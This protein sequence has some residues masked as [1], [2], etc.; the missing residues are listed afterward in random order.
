MNGDTPERASGDVATGLSRRDSLKWLGLLLAGN[1]VAAVPSRVRAA[2]GGGSV[3]GHWP[4]LKLAPVTAKGYGQDPDLMRLAAGPWPRTLTAA[5]LATVSML[6]AIL[7]PREGD[8]PSAAELHVEDV[9]DEWLSAPYEN[10]RHDRAPVL[11]LLRWLDDES[12]ARFDRRFADID[13]ARRLQIVDDIAWLEAADEFRRPAD[14]FHRLRSIVV[15]AFF[16]TPEGSK[17]LGYMGGQVIAGD[18][19]G[20]SKEALA[21]LGAV[22][23]SLDLDAVAD[24]A[25]A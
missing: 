24:P 1:L 15:A 12:V 11:S 8:V 7:V 22:L 5:E 17:D 16:C 9:V 20:P 13:E 18:Y 25:L 4:E 14:A 6:A 2:T 19:P 21:H 3:A 10:Q 23:K